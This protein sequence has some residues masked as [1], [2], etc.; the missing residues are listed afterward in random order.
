MESS[1]VG[2]FLFLAILL[3]EYVAIV[4][5]HYAYMSWFRPTWAD[6]F[7]GHMYTNEQHKYAIEPP[8]PHYPPY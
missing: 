5:S 8:T 7:E 2:L 3:L 4:G 6:L 1:F